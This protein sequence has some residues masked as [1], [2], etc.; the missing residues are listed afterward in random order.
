MDPLV[1]MNA[2]MKTKKDKKHKHSNK[3]DITSKQKEKHIKLAANS[4][5]E[6][7]VKISNPKTIEQ[8]RAERL[9]RESDERIKAQRLLTGNKD[10]GKLKEKIEVDDRKRKYNNQFNPD[11]AKF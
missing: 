4:S 5:L 6:A 8:M 10:D 3:K 1:T 9:K 11:Y 2:L 7:I